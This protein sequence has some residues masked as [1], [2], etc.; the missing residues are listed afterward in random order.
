[1][2]V[3]LSSSRSQVSSN[4]NDGHFSQL[5]EED[6]VLMSEESFGG[7]DLYVDSRPEKKVVTEFPRYCLFLLHPESCI[8]F[9]MTEDLKTSVMNRCS[10]RC[11]LASG[12]DGPFAVERFHLEKELSDVPSNPLMDCESTQPS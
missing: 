8:V 3:S 12:M 6:A 5:A 1:M 7:E 4:E 9:C 2:N 11:F 10:E